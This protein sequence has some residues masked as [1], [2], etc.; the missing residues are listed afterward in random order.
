MPLMKLRKSSAKK[1]K[2]PKN[3]RG[4]EW[5]LENAWF[6]AEDTVTKQKYSYSRFPYQ[7]EIL[8]AMTDPAIER[9]VV[10][11][12]SQIGKT[13]MQRCTQ[14]FF[15]DQ[16]PSPMLMIQ[17]TLTMAEAYSKDRLAPFIR[18]TPALCDKIKD[19]R[20]RDSG[21]TLLHKRFPGGHITMAGANSPASL[22]SRPIRV[23][24]FD[25]V[26]R[27][28]LSAG[29]EGDPLE[30]GVARTRRFWNRKI[31]IVSTPTIT[32]ISRID[33]EFD[34]SDKRFFSVPCPSC[35]HEQVLIF[36]NLKWNY[37]K[38]KDRFKSVY[39]EC[40]N[41]SHAI[42]EIEKIDMIRKGRFI[43]TQNS[44]I[45][46]FHV[47]ELYILDTT[48]EELIRDFLKSKDR[49][50][51]LQV[52]INTR[53][54]E[55]FDDYGEA[56]DYKHIML[57]ANEHNRNEIDERVIFLTAAVDVQND[58]IEYEVRGW[59]RNLE[60][61]SIDYQ[62]EMG[63]TADQKVF[64]KLD[65]LLQKTW[66]HP[67]GALLKIAGLGIDTGGKNTQSVYA[68]CR[69][70][71]P[72][73]VFPLKGMALDNPVGIPKAVDVT[74]K[75]KKIQRGLK[76]WGVGSSILKS[77]LYNN[78]RLQ[79]NSEDTGFPSGF[80]HFPA[81]DEDYFK[82]L[83]AEVLN[84]KIVKGRKRMEWEQIR[85]RNEALDIAV[86]NRA[87]S[88]I[89]GIDRMSPAAWDKAEKSLLVDTRTEPEKPIKKET[90]SRQRLKGRRRTISPGLKR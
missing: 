15:I 11:S 7:R 32:G 38:K 33:F 55:T 73:K 69:R 50:E 47:S 41:C 72:E 87:A 59:G 84:V 85:K 45:V 42:G 76:V 27:Y 16:E 49:R 86:Y 8:D 20:A 39:Y 40:E 62:V 68:W 6:S 18:D 54:G 77:E 26:D 44:L 63:D 83:T 48:W 12:S 21:N 78:L 66:L 37:D 81:Y 17:P 71:Q 13:I 82:Q 31:I 9:V 24:F 43:K 4:S 5:A 22:A 3:L 57:R 88:I 30:L 14:G 74:Y 36:K 23:V 79:V 52:F 10:K 58:R 19:P 75:G 64:S 25:E 35:N 89:L 67:K 70:K 28:P 51:L 90:D 2:P 56:P 53:L 34:K 29:T 46:G 1:L 80:I 61:W 65:E 60:S